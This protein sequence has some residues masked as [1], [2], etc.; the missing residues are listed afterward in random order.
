MLELDNIIAV[1]SE[2]A[3]SFNNYHCC[4]NIHIPRTHGHDR[5]T[6]FLFLIAYTSEVF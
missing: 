2:T 3:P 1:K 4:N 5:I 6:R